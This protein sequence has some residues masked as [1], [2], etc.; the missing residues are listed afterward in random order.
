MPA[1]INRSAA[2]GA[3]DA[4]TGNLIALILSDQALL[5]DVAG[6]P[7]ATE[8]LLRQARTAAT[9]PRMAT[10]RLGAFYQKHGDAAAA[11]KV[12][13]EVARPTNA[14]GTRQFL[15]LQT[16]LTEGKKAEAEQIARPY[17]HTYPRPSDLART[18]QE[19]RKK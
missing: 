17:F 16:L 3:S 1:A 11:E 14:E 13:R 8:A 12:L 4:G 15:L 7:A 19:L 5:A 9:E 2:G 6:N 18:Y 10:L